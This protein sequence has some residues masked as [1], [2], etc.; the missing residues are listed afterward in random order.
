MTDRILNLT[1]EIISLLTGEDYTIVKKTFADHINSGCGPSGSIGAVICKELVMTSR[2]PSVK[3]ETS[4][5]RIL[6]LTNQIIQ[7]LTGELMT[8]FCRR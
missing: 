2:R 8:P 5:E 4:N 7:L 6:Q 1:L 3:Q